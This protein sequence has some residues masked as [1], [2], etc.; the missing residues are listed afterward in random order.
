MNRTW[1]VTEKRDG[2]ESAETRALRERIAELEREVAALQR[3]IEELRDTIR[4]LMRPSRF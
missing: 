1:H 4:V 3:W 2:S